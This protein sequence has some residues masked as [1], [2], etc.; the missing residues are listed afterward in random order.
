MSQEQQKRHLV[1]VLPEPKTLNT[2]TASNDQTASILI[3][4]HTALRIPPSRAKELVPY[5]NKKYPLGPSLGHLKRITKQRQEEAT[6]PE[7]DA[8]L[9]VLIDPHVPGTDGLDVAND[10]MLGGL[11][12]VKVKIPALPAR[13]R[14]EWL[15][16][17]WPSIF[18]AAQQEWTETEQTKLILEIASMH[19]EGGEECPSPRIT[20]VDSFERKLIKQSRQDQ[21]LPTMNPIEHSIMKLSIEI[22]DTPYLFSGLIICCDFEPC[23]LCA[24]AL[25][26]SRVHAVLLCDKDGDTVP[27]GGFADG[28]YTKYGIHAQKG[29]NH[30][31]NVYRLAKMP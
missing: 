25:I 11:A 21:C 1:K 12:S 28:P 6:Q 23:L 26:H 7:E 31:H 20:F 17:P 8:N 2:A 18:H 5:L 14:S 19:T 29:L 22:Q 15:A 4:E 24:M 13:N 9:L 16:S 10:P 30:H 27:P 3:T